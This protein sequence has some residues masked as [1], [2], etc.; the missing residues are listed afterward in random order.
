VVKIEV[1]VFMVS[2]STR[3]CLLSWSSDRI[4]IKNY[5]I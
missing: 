2:Q 1:E 3:P 5:K 4:H